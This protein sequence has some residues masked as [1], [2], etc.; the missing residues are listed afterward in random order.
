MTVGR[1]GFPQA[2]PHAGKA[3]PDSFGWAFF[4]FLI[5]EMEGNQEAG[6]RSAG[7]ISYRKRGRFSLLFFFIRNRLILS[8]FFL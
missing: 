5:R 1:S 7:E 4:Y 3:C 8:H 6:L 2:R